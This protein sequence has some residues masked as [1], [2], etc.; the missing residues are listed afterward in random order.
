MAKSTPADAFCVSAITMCDLY[1]RDDWNFVFGLA[2]LVDGVG[3]YSLTRY[4]PGFF[5]AEH[6]TKMDTLNRYGM[7]ITMKNRM[8]YEKSN[9]LF[10]VISCASQNSMCRNVQRH[11]T[12]CFTGK[13]CT[14]VIALSRPI[15]VSV[16]FTA[17]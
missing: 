5:E 4:T 12:N 9:F 8:K 7:P 16:T 1:P 2:R 3:V 14:N 11:V 17:V 15:K 6:S 13:L 10:Y